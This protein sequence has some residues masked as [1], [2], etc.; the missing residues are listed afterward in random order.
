MMLTKVIE[1]FEESF[2]KYGQKYVKFIFI[3]NLMS[4]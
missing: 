4:I 2:L 1:P 3:E